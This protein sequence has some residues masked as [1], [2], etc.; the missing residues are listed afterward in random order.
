LEHEIFRYGLEVLLGLIET[1]IK[2]Y[3]RMEPKWIYVPR[4]PKIRSQNGL[5][6]GAWDE[7]QIFR[8]AKNALKEQNI[9]AKQ[10][11]NTTVNDLLIAI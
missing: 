9:V 2:R 11:A 4:Q 10:R 5:P 8:E 1:E 3:R 6:D 7:I